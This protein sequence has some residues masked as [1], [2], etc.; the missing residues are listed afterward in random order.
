MGKT[1]MNDL[2][3]TFRRR[4]LPWLGGLLLLACAF[5]LFTGNGMLAGAFCLGMA[6]A[7]A[8]L[9]SLARRL[10]QM[11][12]SSV[13]GM[14]GGM[15]LRLLILAALLLC[16]ASVSGEVLLAAAA[17]FLLAF[18][19]VLLGLILCARSGKEERMKGDP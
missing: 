3:S 17:G 5:L 8:Y 6:A 7:L 4:I 19:V 14:P 16:A 2:L 13:R 18:L 10:W 15:L 1:I 12:Q 11:A 9:W